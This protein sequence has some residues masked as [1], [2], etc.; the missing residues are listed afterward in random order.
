MD[1]VTQQNAALV[2][3]AAAAAASMREQAA[4]LSEAVSVFQ[5]DEAGQTFIHARVNRPAIA[6]TSSA[7]AARAL[8]NAR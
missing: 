4:T 2:E 7:T 3:Q 6:I 5:L 1:I 8:T